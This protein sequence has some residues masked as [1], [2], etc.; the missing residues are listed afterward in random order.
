VKP[1]ACLICEE[2]ILKADEHCVGDD[3]VF[4]EGDCQGWLHRQCAGVTHPAFDET[5]KVYYYVFTLYVSLS[6]Q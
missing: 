6:E 4:C 1:T 5:D 2:P 3:A